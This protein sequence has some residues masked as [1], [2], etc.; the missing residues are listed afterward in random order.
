MNYEIIN[1][2]A[3]RIAQHLDSLLYWGDGGV[4]VGG[5]SIFCFVFFLLLYLKECL[6]TNGFEG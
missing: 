5:R 4:C 1:Q 2:P 6:E 3:N